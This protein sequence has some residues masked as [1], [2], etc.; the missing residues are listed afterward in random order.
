LG[1][2]GVLSDFDVFCGSTMGAGENSA[3]NLGTPSLPSG[4]SA[5]DLLT[6]A[7]WNSQNPQTN[8]VFFLFLLPT[9]KPS[10]LLRIA[11]FYFTTTYCMYT[12]LHTHTH[13]H[14]LT[15]GCQQLSG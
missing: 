7:P 10:C 14:T 11:S 9:A 8:Q 6:T 2:V 3:L 12:I 15:R 5:K 13:T 1:S 4:V